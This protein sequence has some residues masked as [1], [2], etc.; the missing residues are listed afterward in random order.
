MANAAFVYTDDFIA[1]KFSDQH[2]LRQY[3]LQMVDRLIAAYGLYERGECGRVTPNP[4]E[5]S[6]LA[7]VHSPDYLDAMRK[8]SQGD[9]VENADAYGF[10]PG[11]N[12]PF[13]GMWEASLLYVGATVDAANL[14]L[15]GKNRYAF[16]SSGGLHHAFRGRATGFCLLNDNAVAAYMALDRGMR[17]AYIDIDAHHGDGTQALFFDNPNVLTVSIHETGRTL[18]P[19]TGFVNETGVD[20][21]E[22]YSINVPMAPWS[23]DEHY[24][25]AFDNAIQ[26]IVRAYDPDFIILNVGADGHWADP[27]AHLQ[28]TSRG[29]ID[30]VDRVLAFDRPTLAL[31]GGGYNVKTVARIWTLLQSRLSG[32]T[33]PDDIP[34]EYAA[35][36]GIDRLHDAEKPV[37]SDEQRSEAWTAVRESVAEL[38]VLVGKRYGL[39]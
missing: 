38:R 34:E 9:D 12:P 8:L 29:W 14:V 18:F 1:Y 10:G 16:N 21:G 6:A 35:Q 26:P 22:C 19:G 5:P 31:G 3:R 30:L 25:Y 15:D 24:A 32:V 7:R 20:A 37:I 11:D 36:Y 13:R 23:T 17:V 28:L 27:L 33:L 4:A 2:P 39:K